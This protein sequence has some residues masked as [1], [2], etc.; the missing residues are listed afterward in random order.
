M[1]RECQRFAIIEGGDG[2]VPPAPFAC[3]RPFEEAEEVRFDCQVI[4]HGGILRQKK[5]SEVSKTSE[6]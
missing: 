6:V 5:T 2:E 3:P 1:A 4:G